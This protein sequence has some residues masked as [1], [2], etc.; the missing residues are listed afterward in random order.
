MKNGIAKLLILILIC[1]SAL[2]Q[3]SLLAATV[4]AGTPI[5][6]RTNGAISTHATPGRHFTATLDQ[7]VGGLRAG[8]KVTGLIQASRGSRSTT[9][10]S[11]LTLVLTGVSS[12]GK[13][14]SIKTSPMHPEGAHTTSTRRGSFSFGEDTF[15]AGTRLEFRLSQPA[16]L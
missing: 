12:D 7:D 1:G 2:T 13:M 9:S 6:V 14:V 16:N 10:S 11:P 5:V 4:P 3:S 8:T 15:P